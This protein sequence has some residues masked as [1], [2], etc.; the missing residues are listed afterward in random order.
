MLIEYALGAFATLVSSALLTGI[1]RR[2]ALTH[3]VL[4]VPNDR[5]S[6]TTPTPRGGGM[7]I[8]VTLLAAIAALGTVGAITPRLTVAMLVSGGV[9]AIVGFA[10]DKWQVAAPIR[11][12]VHISAVSLYVWILG[13]L[14]PIDF[15]VATWN[16]GVFGTVLG[17]L[18]MVWFLNLYNFMDGIDGIAGVEAISVAAVAAALL[19][20]RGTESPVPL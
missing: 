12:I 10:D 3:R 20:F 17:V 2:L 19:M 4:D 7:A 16:L 1:V 6:H 18:S 8:V 13:R 11:L 15:G 9:V 5:S 14:P